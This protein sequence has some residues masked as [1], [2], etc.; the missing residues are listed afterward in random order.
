MQLQTH[1]V[2]EMAVEE[3]LDAKDPLRHLM[4]VEDSLVAVRDSSSQLLAFLPAQSHSVEDGLLRLSFSSDR[5][6]VPRPLNISL[7]VDASPG[8]GGIAW[9]A[10]QIL[11]TYL[12]QRD[13][14]YLRDKNVLELGAGTGLVGLVAGELEADC[15]VVI[16]DQAPLLPIM[17]KN[18]ALNKL[19]SNVVVAELDWGSP[20]PAAIPKPDI[21]LAADC[22]YF[23]PAF[24]LL[25]QTLA[26]LADTSTEILFCYKKRRKAD[27]RFFSMLKKKFSWKE[28]MDDPNREIY[29]K[30][31]ITLMRLFKR[32]K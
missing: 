27:K 15:R 17:Q 16:T 28:V 18:V 31:A 12:V 26:D 14:G 20:I 11:A 19:G 22:V 29:M 3:E 6:G 1:A 4:G 2:P 10:G 25:V 24:P 23:E 9:P 8:C 5:G 32:Q 13:L 21:I 7:A 30:E